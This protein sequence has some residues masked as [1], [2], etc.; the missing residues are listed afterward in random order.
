MFEQD[1]NEQANISGADFAIMCDE[2]AKLRADLAAAQEELR[3]AREQVP[4]IYVC[5]KKGTGYQTIVRSEF[6]ASIYQ[7]DEYSVTPYYAA[8]VPAQPQ[9]SWNVCKHCLNTR[10]EAQPQPA[11]YKGWYCAHCQTG[12]DSR[13]VTFSEQHTVCGRVITD[14]EPPAPEG[15][16]AW[17]EN[18]D[19]FYETECGNSFQFSEGGAADNGAVYC[20]YCGKK[21]DEHWFDDMPEGDT[22]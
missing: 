1:P 11:P 8:P 16:C 18:D 20:Q 4:D 10:K 3:K 9:P 6:S 15:T 14:D 12:V 13:E 5:H 21:I 2:M 19:G 7:N 22:Q 17:S